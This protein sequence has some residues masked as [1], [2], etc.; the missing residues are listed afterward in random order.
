MSLH[1]DLVIRYPLPASLTQEL[2]LL[3]S[4]L[5]L[6]LLCQSCILALWRHHRLALHT[7]RRA[8]YRQEKPWLSLSLHSHHLSL[9]VHTLRLTK[10]WRR[11]RRSLFPGLRFGPLTEDTR[12]ESPSRGRST[13][14]FL[15]YRTHGTR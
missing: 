8:L 15:N 12:Q 3:L 2:L 10:P 5:L 11:V 4:L 6:D 9:R 14:F 1:E 13:P 7:K